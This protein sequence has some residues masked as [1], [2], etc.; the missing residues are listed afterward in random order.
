M[1]EAV[2]ILACQNIFSSEE[3]LA[4]AFTSLVVRRPAV[5]KYNQPDGPWMRTNRCRSVAA[6]RVALTFRYQIPN[7][8]IRNQRVD[9]TAKSTWDNK[10]KRL[11]LY[12]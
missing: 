11:Y 6:A 8:N 9:N 5:K 7:E 10:Q 4:V 3:A 1:L 12:V 2:D